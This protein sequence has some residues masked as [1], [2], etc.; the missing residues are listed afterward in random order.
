[1]DLNEVRTYFDDYAPRW[2]AEMIRNE[3]AIET[4]LRNTRIPENG[5]VLDVACGTG[6]L[7]PDYFAHGAGRVVGVDI[8]SGMIEIAKQKFTG[9]NVELVCADASEFWT[10]ERFDSV[11]IYNAFPHF[12]EPKQ[13]IHHLS[14]LLKPGGILTVAHGMGKDMLD[15]HHA[16]SARH[17]SRK[18]M[19]L[20]E[21]AKIF[22]K[23]LT[24]D[25]LIS[26][27]EI[28][29]VAGYR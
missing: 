18:L 9:M 23:D 24:V 26:T 19:P 22:E 10:K 4:I 13:L 2:D 20:A 11:V 6:V 14:G 7:I 25:V 27:P 12:T 16:G 28:Y 15:E 1:M 21:L 17:V 8:S 29:Q 5:T 3:F